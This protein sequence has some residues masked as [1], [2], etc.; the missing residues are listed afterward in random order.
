MLQEISRIAILAAAALA[1]LSG[2]ATTDAEFADIDLITEVHP[3]FDL[4]NYGSY[5]WEG[6]ASIIY[7]PEGRW[8]PP[9]YDLD[10]E[11]R[12]LVDSEL[13]EKGL[14]QSSTRPDL[15]A[16]F[17]IAIQFEDLPFNRDPSEEME[18]IDEVP[19]GALV[20]YLIDP[21][22]GYAVWAGLAAADVDETPDNDLSRRRLQYAVSN[23]LSSLSE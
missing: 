8:E 4:S 3:R 15:L 14:V 23:L 13:R 2:C 11:V 7:D 5:A 12:F 19:Q 9:A 16:S 17:G 18:V 1:I 10:D 22:L 20:I 21:N 6:N